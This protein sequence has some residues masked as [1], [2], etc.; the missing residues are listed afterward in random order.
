MLRIR[1]GQ[2]IEQDA[3]LAPGSEAEEKAR[4][5]EA[6]REPGDDERHTLHSHLRMD[7]AWRTYAPGQRWTGG[8]GHEIRAVLRAPQA[9]AV[10][11][12][13][14]ELAL[15]PT[16]DEERIVGRLGPDPL[17]DDWD[18]DEVTRRLL[19]E[20]ETAVGEA[21]LDQTKLAGVGNLYRCEAL[22]LRGLSPW[23]PV[24]EVPEPALLAALAGRLLVANRGRWTQSSTGSLRRGEQQWVFERAGSPCRRC[25]TTIRR[26]PTSRGPAGWPMPL[27]VPCDAGSGG[28]R[29]SRAWRGNRR[30]GTR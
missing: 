14:H 13:L 16:G 22:F 3:P 5:E 26:W 1:L 23:T 17:G 21:L 7:G 9:V 30:R 19:A 6:E 27:P 12:H 29:P 11:Y 15:V 24:G 4:L 25:G 8:P 18:V 28:D 10:G 2:L 20:P